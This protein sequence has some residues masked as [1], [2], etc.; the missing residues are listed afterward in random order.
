MRQLAFLVAA[1]SPA[2]GLISSAANAADPLPASPAT[3]P[4]KVASQSPR[5]ING[6]AW[7]ARAIAAHGGLERWK[8]QGT[9]AFSLTGFPLTPAL[10][11]PNRSTIDLTARFNR[12]D[13]AG[14]S[15]AWDG[16][17]A[18]IAPSADAAGLPPRFFVRGSMYFLIMPFVFADDGITATDSGPAVFGGVTY[19]RV[20]VTYAE[21]V[22]DVNDVY[23]LFF[24]QKSHRLAVINHSVKG[25]GIE[26]VT[27]TFDR[28]QEV[29]GLLVPRVMTFR[30]GWNPEAP[31]EGKSVDVTEV[32]F[33]RARPPASLYQVRPGDA[34]VPD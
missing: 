7:L 26:R 25:A 10:A 18:W 33:D 6:S 28:W 34:V 15:A 14:F 2:L 31:G 23:D 21:G 9:M 24:D 5:T 12:I 19:D 3:S 29:D 11:K 20:H 30:A 32:R 22:G 16:R 1:A 27:W 8:A 4:S 17:E 13:G